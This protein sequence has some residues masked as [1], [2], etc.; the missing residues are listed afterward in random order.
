MTST[1][2]KSTSTVT[3]VQSECSDHSLPG[4]RD[5]A[6]SPSSRTPPVDI[7]SRRSLE[8]SE[9]PCTVLTPPEADHDQVDS[10]RVSA[11]VRVP[12]G[13]GGYV[14]MS[15][16]VSHN[17]GALEEQSS[18]AILEESLEGGG[19]WRNSPRHHSPSF[20]KERSRPDS[21]RNSSCYDDSETHWDYEW[22]FVPDCAWL[23][24]AA[25]CA[26]AVIGPMYKWKGEHFLPTDAPVGDANGEPALASGQ[27]LY[28]GCPPGR[29]RWLTSEMDPREVGGVLDECAAIPA[30]AA[31]AHHALSQPADPP[32]AAAQRHARLGPAARRRADPSSC[33]AH[34]AR[35]DPEAHLLPGE[36]PALVRQIAS[37]T[38]QCFLVH[39]EGGRGI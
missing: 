33:H 17:L 9:A 1:P 30:T 21:K 36:P 32:L 35:W 34:A 8:G 31:L 29:K 19:H 2:L 26:P 39:R 37:L 10:V 5:T 22:S 16:G 11:K 28:S 23:R 25:L 6:S 24:P 12:S 38:L 20:I 14:D 7:F 27:Q 15:P 13:D 3:L 18:L 4:P